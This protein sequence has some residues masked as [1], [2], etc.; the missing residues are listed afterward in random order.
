MQKKGKPTKTSKRVKKINREFAVVSS[1]F[2][3]IFAALMIHVCYYQFFCSETV[4]NNAYNKRPFVFAD[5]VE[6]GSIYS[7]DGK[8]LAE[9][10]VDGK[11]N[12]VR[13]YPYNEIFAHAVG[14]STNGTTG[15]ES[16]ANFSLLRSN[17]SVI[18]KICNFFAG[19]KHQG[20]SIITTFDSSLQQIAYE[21]MGEY[22]GAVIVM[23]PSN[24]NILAMVSKPDFNPNTILTDY[25][26]LIGEGENGET[27]SALFNRATQGS[28]TPGSIFKVITTIEYLRQYSDDHSYHYACNGEVTVQNVCIH[29][30]N[31]K[32]HGELTLES[33]FAYSCNGAYSTMGLNLNIDQFNNTCRQLLFNGRLPIPYPYTESIFELDNQSSTAAIMRASFGQHTTTVSPLHMLLITSAIANDGVLMTPRV[34]DRVV[35]ENGVLIDK[36]PEEAY[37]S[38]LT[39]QEAEYIQKY[40]EA[41]V[42]YGT[43]KALKSEE[44]TA[45]GKTGSAQVSDINENTHAWFIGYAYDEDGKQIAIAVIVENRGYGSTYAVPVAKKI[46][47]VY[48]SK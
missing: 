33:A 25:D 4:I 13:T 35:N 47:D 28:Y 24:G 15:I 12:E 14:Y 10:V 34:I 20:D 11:G 41:T 31:N 17:T 23:D 38:L 43:A 3:I 22:D 21:A 9:T 36:Y 32:A 1:F 8:V 6:R 29:C 37:G 39:K 45:A 18:K 5:K 27:G 48:F 42:A 16:I 30:V 40:M 26:K 2:V 19:K 7:A 46:F 44:Y